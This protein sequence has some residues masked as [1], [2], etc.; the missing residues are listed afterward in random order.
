MKKGRTSRK[1][2]MPL[3]SSHW[4]ERSKEVADAKDFVPGEKHK[5]GEFFDLQGRVE[6]GR[7]SNHNAATAF[8]IYSRTR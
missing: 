4:G 3:G 1:H 2:A 7:S 8:M 5:A 6:K